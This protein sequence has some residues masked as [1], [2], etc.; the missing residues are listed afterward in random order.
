MEEYKPKLAE[1]VQTWI[2]RAFGVG[3]AGIVI[4]ASYEYDYKKSYFPVCAIQRDMNHDGITDLVIQTRNGSKEIMLG[5][6]DGSYYSNPWISQQQVQTNNIDDLPC[7]E[8]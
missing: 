8:P 7:E 2:W 5:R 4:Y 6:K 1:R 3:L